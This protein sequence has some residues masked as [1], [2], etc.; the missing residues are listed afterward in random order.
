MSQIIL[1]IPDG[2]YDRVI[3]NFCTAY[4]YDQSSGVDKNK[5]VQQSILNLMFSIV[6][7]QEAEMAIKTAKK[8]AEDKVDA[9]VVLKLG[10]LDNA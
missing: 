10:A 9:E 8:I 7:S 6:K 3:D 1:E 2:I 5:F 4:N